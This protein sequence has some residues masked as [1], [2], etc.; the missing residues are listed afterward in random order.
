[1]N[2]KLIMMMMMVTGYNVT[3]RDLRAG[4]SVRVYNQCG[5]TQSYEIES[6]AI[7]KMAEV[8]IQSYTLYDWSN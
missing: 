5:R 7:K 8:K 2:V 3:N 6:L 4:Q 1:M